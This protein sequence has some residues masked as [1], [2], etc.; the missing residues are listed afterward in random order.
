MVESTSVVRIFLEQ[1]SLE[2]YCH[3]L[4]SQGYKTA[5]DLCLL[6]EEDLDSI[7]ILNP[8]ERTR[9]LK[10]AA[11]LDIQLWLK[12]LGLEDY[13]N[14]FKREGILTVKDL[15]TRSITDDLL[16]ALE[17]MI[18]GHRKRLKCA[19]SF[20]KGYNSPQGNV[21]KVVTVG[22]WGQ[23]PNMTDNTHPF[24][25]VPGYLKSDTGDQASSSEVI[26][27]ILDSG[28]EV[29]V[30]VPQDLISKLKLEYLHD[31]ESRGVHASANTQAYRGVLMLG[32][33]EIPVEV[34]A[35]RFATVGNTVMRKFKHYINGTFH[36]WLKDDPPL[37]DE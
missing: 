27:F 16:D 23:P 9:I 22:Y 21:A 1:I 13:L 19:V 12:H 26:Q 20:L 15:Q 24:L 36:R 5:L 10:A 17:V 35:D 37:P 29:G 34:M 3:R 25:C 14:E 33:E 11:E 30:T 32:S 6:D 18:P 2:Q 4:E 7:S 8:E 28:S 31:I